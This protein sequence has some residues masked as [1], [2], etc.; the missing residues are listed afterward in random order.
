MAEIKFTENNGNYVY[1]YTSTGTAVVQVQTAKPSKLNVAAAVGS[2][3][4]IGIASVGSSISCN[5]LCVVDVPS[6][7]N[8]QLLTTEEVVSAEMIEVDE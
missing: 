5:A 4:P 3:T 7:L 8:V 1:N 2:M 6:G